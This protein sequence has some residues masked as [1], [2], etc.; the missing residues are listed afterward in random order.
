VLT[1]E[2]WVAVEGGD[3]SNGP[4]N[5][6]DRGP[7]ADALWAGVLAAGE[8]F[9]PPEGYRGGQRSA[10][11]YGQAA[12]VTGDTLEWVSAVYTWNLPDGT[13]LHRKVTVTTIDTVDNND[14]FWS[15]LSADDAGA[16][17]EEGQHYFI[18]PPTST[19][20]KGFGGK[21]WHI[22]FNDG[23]PDVYTDNLWS[24]GPIPPAHRER[25]PDNAEVHVMGH[26]TCYVCGGGAEVD[27]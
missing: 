13:R 4:H 24:Q 23:R 6:Q 17:R 1:P 9:E 19:G 7:L 8:Q 25:L 5:P 21:R 22:V 18:G 16:V 2:Q 26:R 14:G 15:K 27:W 20:M 11:H 3:G 10:A 12:P